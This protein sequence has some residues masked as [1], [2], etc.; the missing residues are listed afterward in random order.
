MLIDLKLEI[1]ENFKGFSGDHIKMETTMTGNTP[2]IIATV[3]SAT[4]EEQVSFISNGNIKI[5]YD[6]VVELENNE[7]IKMVVEREI[8]YKTSDEYD[9]MNVDS[10]FTLNLID[11]VFSEGSL[12]SQIMVFL[13]GPKSRFLKNYRYVLNPREIQR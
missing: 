12:E 9:A 6:T 4:I 8:K 2:L 5:S 7:S 11:T 10:G 1:T 3:Q 13:T